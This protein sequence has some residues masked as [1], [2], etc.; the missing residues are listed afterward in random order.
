M[1]LR[2]RLLL[3]YIRPCPH[4]PHLLPSRLSSDIQGLGLTP[5]PNTGR[6]VLHGTVPRGIGLPGIDL[7]GI[8]PHG[9]VHTGTTGDITVP[10]PLLTELPPVPLYVHPLG[11]GL[12]HVRA[13]IRQ[14]A[15]IR[16][17]ITTESHPMSEE[18]P[19]RIFVGIPG[20]LVQRQSFMMR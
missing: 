2:L 5:L 4:G 13:L 16:D 6:I 15:R 17:N 10:V 7:P 11:L 9:T 3:H 12:V 20:H 18:T 8:D 19:L 1:H 14:P